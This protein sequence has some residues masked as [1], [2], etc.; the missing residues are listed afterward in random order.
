MILDLNLD[1]EDLEP[2]PDVGVC[3][4]CGWRGDLA[5]CEYEREGDYFEGYH[6]VAICPVCEDGGCVD[7]Y[8]M[9]DEQS[10]RWEQWKAR[11]EQ[12]I[13]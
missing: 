6:D 9:S 7:Q 2:Q 10:E 5:S 3:A 4:D 11:Q 1:E 8:D 13:K 12:K